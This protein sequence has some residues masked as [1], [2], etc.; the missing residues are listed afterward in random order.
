MVKVF[1]MAVV[2]Y[3]IQQQT[4][5]EFIKIGNYSGKG[6]KKSELKHSQAAPTVI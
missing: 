2:A 5:K 1:K 3:F 4:I 6:G